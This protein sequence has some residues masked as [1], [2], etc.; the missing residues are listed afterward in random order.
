MQPSSQRNVEGRVNGP[1]AQ[2][3]VAQEKRLNPSSVPPF[4]GAL[5]GQLGNLG[6]ERNL[7]MR[8]VA[9]GSPHLHAPDPQAFHLWPARV[10]GPLLEVT[11][12][13]GPWSREPR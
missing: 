3:P 7:E 11:E 10:L 4:L 1:G 9:G 12:S 13:E 8:G 5:E 2:E 6:G